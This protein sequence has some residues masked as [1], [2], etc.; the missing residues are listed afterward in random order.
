MRLLWLRL[1]PISTHALREEGDSS[2]KPF[3][4]GAK[5][6]THALREEGDMLQH[7]HFPRRSYFYP[8]PPR[9]GRRIVTRLAQES[10]PIS[11]HA[12]RE[13]GDGYKPGWAWYQ[14]KISTHALREEGDYV[15]CAG[16]AKRGDFY[17]RPPRGGRREYDLTGVVLDRFL[18]TPSA[19]RATPVCAGRAVLGDISTH[20]L[21]EEGDRAV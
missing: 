17:P 1:A 15:G 4:I 3:I 9:G 18:P 11:T 20:A 10:A 5:I 12:L 19:R 14:A 6:S 2:V 13:E 7:H 21:R 16:S 8:R